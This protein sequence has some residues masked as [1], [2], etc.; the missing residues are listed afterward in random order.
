L[1]PNSQK[2]ELVCPILDDEHHT[3]DPESS[4]SYTIRDLVA[5]DFI[6]PWDSPD[7]FI[8]G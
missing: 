6:M 1:I 5:V 3:G 7:G 4:D 8:S 2:P